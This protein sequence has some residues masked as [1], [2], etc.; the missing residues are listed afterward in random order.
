MDKTD[1]QEYWGKARRDQEVGIGGS[2]RHPLVA[3][4]L[5]VGAV[6]HQLLLPRHRVLDR[7]ATRCGMPAADFSKLIVFSSIVHDL[8]KLS[9]R[10]QNLRPDLTPP[11]LRPMRGV[12]LRHDAVGYGI[13]QWRV[14][15]GVGATIHE[16]FEPPHS[17]VKSLLRLLDLVIGA[18]IGHHGVPVF[19]NEQELRRE[20]YAGDPIAERAL[21]LFAIA[22]RCAGLPVAP[23]LDAGAV[24]SAWKE[25]SWWI[26]G[27]L[28]L[29]D[30]V[31]SNQI[32]F[33]FEDGPVD[34][35]KYWREHALPRAKRAVDGSGVQPPPYPGA[36]RLADLFPD[37][38]SSRPLQALAESLS[39]GD[40]PQCLILEDVPGSGKTEAAILL[41]ARLMAGNQATGLYFALPTMATANAMYERLSKPYR[42][43]CG[44]GG[45]A[46]LS[47]AHGA[48]RLH[49]GFVASYSDTRSD[50][51]AAACNNW[52]AESNKRALLAP[53]SVGTIDQALLAVLPNRHQNLRLSAL[54]D[55]VLLVD[56]VHACDDYVLSLLRVLLTRHA[57]NGGS[58]ILLS[59]TLPRQDRQA[60]LAAWLD[61]LNGAEAPNSSESHY[62]MLTQCSSAGVREEASSCPENLR[63]SH[64]V[65]LAAE[66]EDV[67]GALI[68]E[69]ARGGCAV[70]VRNTV[71]DAIRAWQSLC[72][73][74]PGDQQ[75]M[76]FHARFALGDRLAREVEVLDAFG[77]LS[78]SAT[79]RGR[80]LVA[81]Q[82]V[83]QS[84]DLDFDLLATDLAPIDLLIQRSGR[85]RRHFRDAM[86]NPA[87]IDSRGE[88]R[89][90]VLSPD[91]DDLDAF[92][93]FLRGPGKGLGAVYPHHHHLWRSARVLRKHGRIS[94]PED[95]RRFV[96]CVY[97]DEIAEATPDV[98]QRAADLAAGTDAARR[99]LAANN[100]LKFQNGYVPLS[101]TAWGDD[102][103]TPTRLGEPTRRLRL[104]CWDGRDLRPMHQAD[105]H[106]WALSEVAIRSVLCGDLITDDVELRRAMTAHIQAH[107]GLRGGLLVPF[108][109]DPSTNEWHASLEARDGGQ[110]RFTYHRGVGLMWE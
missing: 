25:A 8:G 2:D 64:R 13:W 44:D 42:R 71:A 5:D 98:L 76:L 35:D 24:L 12:G 87:G 95:A 20:T 59:A 15:S 63:R 67:E 47:L 55:K 4:C 86:G 45:D 62:P 7:W 61:G 29:A 89:V 30:W 3:H 14:R 106:A 52:L 92:T 77:K 97:D 93:E 105:D 109:L 36:S 83:E 16:Y 10:F 85:C 70:W 43:L 50:D 49:E 68:E 26:N 80:I 88:G 110:R 90:L 17:N 75:P 60:L 37:I 31:G 101:A 82:V 33:P 65:T 96:E 91:P 39:L 32:Y 104:A 107:N 22:A 27:L 57:A 56:E 73:R 28:V 1:L 54:A 99:C 9:V 94:L 108:T 18:A 23:P 79:R 69:A 19:C 81:T 38:E 21:D 46:S 72:A 84:L 66:P 58:A 6:A 74:L 11:G 41:S 40:G 100:T 103:Y 48:S 51:S 102:E 78:T 34:P 53:V